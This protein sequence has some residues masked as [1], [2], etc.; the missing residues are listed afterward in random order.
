MAHVYYLRKHLESKPNLYFLLWL[1]IYQKMPFIESI[2]VA[3]KAPSTAS[4]SSKCKN[5]KGNEIVDAICEMHSNC[6]QVELAQAGYN[7]EA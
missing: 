5:E 7:A 3:W 2:E 4:S 6:M 1:Q